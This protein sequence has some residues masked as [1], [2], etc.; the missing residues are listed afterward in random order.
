MERSLASVWVA[1]RE[2]ANIVLKLYDGVRDGDT[3]D[4][5]LAT[6]NRDTIAVGKKLHIAVVTIR[7]DGASP[8]FS[9]RIYAYDVGLRDVGSAA[10]P[11]GLKDLGL[12][13]DE[14]DGKKRLPLG[15]ATG[16]LPAFVLPP[17]D[18]ADLRL[19]TG[20]CRKAHN[21]DVDA[22]PALDD[23]LSNGEAYLD[24]AKRPHQMFL[25]G[26]Q[27]YADEVSLDL[28]NALTPIGAELI[29]GDADSFVERLPFK[30]KVGDQE[31]WG[32]PVATST[33]PP[34]RR[35]RLLRRQ[36]GLTTGSGGSHVLSFGEFAA[37]YL[38][39]WSDV[40]Y[41]DDWDTEALNSLKARATAFE[42]AWGQLKGAFDAATG[43][44]DEQKEAAEAK[45]E[46]AGAGQ[47][48]RPEW[49]RI[50]K[51]LD[52]AARKADW[53]EE[54]TGSF[55][56]GAPPDTVS[57]VSAP[58]P[59][60]PNNEVGKA[61]ARALTPSW[62]AGRNELSFRFDGKDLTRDRSLSQIRAVL[63]FKKGLPKVRRLLANVPTYMTFDDHEVT[64]DWNLTGSWVADVNARPMG[65]AILR[66]GL[67]AHGLFQGWGNDPLYFDPPEGEPDTPGKAMLVQAGEMYLDAG[68]A[69]LDSSPAAAPS[70]ALDR[71]FNLGQ[72]PPTPPEERVRWHWSVGG[73]G[74]EV[75]SLD[76][77]TMRGFPT[78]DGPPEL[79]TKE[80]LQLQIPAT[81]IY[82]YGPPGEGAGV[83]FV[84]AAAPV[85]G[86]PPVEYIVQP[87]VNTLDRMSN[88]PTG[89]LAEAK[90]DYHTGF[91][92]HDPEPWSY[93]EHTFEGLLERL[94]PYRRV[95][96][97]SGDVHYSC[98]LK[99]DYW[100]Y[101]P[102]AAEGEPVHTAFVQVT[103]SAFRNQTSRSKINLFQSGFINQLTRVLGI[104]RERL[105]FR[106][107]GRQP[108]LVPPQG[109]P[110]SRT[111]EAQNHA[112]LALFPV[113]AIPEGTHQLYRPSFA[114]RLGLERDGRADGDRLN[115]V[116]GV[117]TL[118]EGPVTGGS[119]TSGT[120]ARHFWETSHVP[121]RFV[122]FLN[123]AGE[124]GVKTGGGLPV[125]VRYT[126]HHALRGFAE[127]RIGP[128]TA[129]DIALGDEGR[130]PAELP[131]V[132]V[133]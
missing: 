82:S 32:I 108:P 50:D 6:G 57:D 71:L 81:P 46:Y 128:F 106:T 40:L 78:P 3:A 123:N 41:P 31:V 113:A 66:N 99:L 105:G 92:D 42:S 85:M 58:R 107:E 91:Y 100:R 60:M 94:A 20:S 90:K 8:L 48:L 127:D 121:S 5:P 83:T 33:F 39:Y 126:V 120:A 132:P 34:A 77:R 18:I 55:P 87:L 51:Y 29:S 24:P 19:L 36:A 131:D 75:L 89:P 17:S 98:C 114:W 53:G 26:D 2:P 118:P 133:G 125:G 119:L 109:V 12:L 73:P 68:G 28:L 93:Q 43:L 88:E 11:K 102:E 103:S 25:T 117:P 35:Q 76:T 62:F 22:M 47:L 122:T 129:F 86:F 21:E 110:F 64:D 23:L 45:L 16:R 65:R 80:A 14:A 124:I 61:L 38:M 95:V 7:F 130:A 54:D 115:K 96:F 30:H 101:D 9:D 79:L 4:T 1:L 37:L 74:Y 84:I 72:T 10:A 44:S 104:P 56:I 116:E 111:I 67:L 13:D 70:A 15:Y 52:A 97:I 59:Q 27:I 49:R 69:A 112:A 63:E